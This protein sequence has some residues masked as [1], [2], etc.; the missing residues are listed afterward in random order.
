M[1]MQTEE[2][3]Q[4]EKGRV[5]GC[6]P[7]FLC[8]HGEHVF[9]LHRT[10]STWH[11]EAQTDL[12]TQ[13]IRCFCVCACVSAGSCRAGPFVRNRKFPVRAAGVEME[14]RTAV[15]RQVASV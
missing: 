3:E 10:W 12:V 11:R 15:S 9:L 4:E 7:T 2:E 5:E 6:K 1:T 13:S 14:R 8:K